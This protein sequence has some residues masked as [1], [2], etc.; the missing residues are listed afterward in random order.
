ME[1]NSKS[2]GSEVVSLDLDDP[3]DMDKKYKQR[4]TQEKVRIV[5]ECQDGE[6]DQ[7][8]MHD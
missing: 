5:V 7:N 6:N 8:N 3:G 1:Q 4:D 2:V